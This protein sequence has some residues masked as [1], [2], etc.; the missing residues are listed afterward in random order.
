MRR[1]FIPIV[2]IIIFVVASYGCTQR[3]TLAAIPYLPPSYYACIET[4]PEELLKAYTA[5]YGDYTKA[6]AIF[7]GQVF[8]FKK[9][10]IDQTMLYDENTFIYSTLTFHA[11]VP[12]SV[13]K[14][15]AGETIDVV[16]VNQGMPLNYPGCLTFTDSI[17]LPTGT[18]ELPAPGGAGFTP[19]Y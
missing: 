14:L 10:R 16:G 4:T 11:L 12:G 1:I 6:Q 19:I 3:S 2:L 8:V 9:L 17:F 18:V 15:K 5:N 7:T 13:A